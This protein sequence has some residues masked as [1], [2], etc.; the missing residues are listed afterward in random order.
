MIFPDPKLLAS[1]SIVRASF[2]IHTSDIH[3]FVIQS[4]MD[5]FCVR[6]IEGASFT[7]TNVTAYFS[8]L[9]N[10]PNIVFPQEYN[11]SPYNGDTFMWTGLYMRNFTVKLPKEL[12]KNGQRPT[13][14]AN[15]LIID[16]SGVS[17]LFTATNLLSLNHGSMTDSGGGRF[18][19]SA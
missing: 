9:S 6:G 12:S 7:A 19:Q 8:E 15:N 4:S 16:H 18:L 10:A 1:D 3:N 14:F 17:G 13:I 2:Q 5:P 11:M